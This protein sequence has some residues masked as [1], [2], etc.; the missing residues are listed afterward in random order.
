MINLTDARR[1]L[2]IDGTDHDEE[3]QQKLEEAIALAAVYVGASTAPPPYDLQD[4]STLTNEE[5][6]AAYDAEA[7]L[8]QRRGIDAA[9]LLIIGDLWMNRESSTGDPLSDAVKNVL[10]LY[11]PVVFT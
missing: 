5:A 6:A 3:I 4:F 9:V 1:H 2:R 7:A 10:G 11:T 8:W